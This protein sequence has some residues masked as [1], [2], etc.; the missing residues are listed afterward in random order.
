MKLILVILSRNL[1]YNEGKDLKFVYQI[2][3]TN[4]LFRRNNIFK[5]ASSNHQ[6]KKVTD[7]FKYLNYYYTSKTSL[8]I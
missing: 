8:Q 2:I 3:L 5:L 7:L 6:S 1:R 4:I